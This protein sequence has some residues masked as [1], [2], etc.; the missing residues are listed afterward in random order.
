M[1]VAPAKLRNRAW[2]RTAC[3]CAYS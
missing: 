3:S 2:A 1:M